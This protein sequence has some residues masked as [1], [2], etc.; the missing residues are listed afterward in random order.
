[1]RRNR[2]TIY[3]ILTVTILLLFYLT[4]ETQ[5]ANIQ[6][7][8]PSYSDVTA[9][10]SIASNGDTVHVPAGFGNWSNTIYL[11]KAITVKGAGA[12]ANDDD[13]CDSTT[14]TCITKTS[15]TGFMIQINLSSSNSPNLTR[16]TGFTFDAN[17]KGE[18]IM[19]LGRSKSEPSTPVP[20][21]RIDNCIFKN[22]NNTGSSSRT[23][24]NGSTQTAQVF[25]VIDSN[26]FIDNAK[27]AIDN[28]GSMCW[29]WDEFSAAESL[30]GVNTLYFEDNEIKFTNNPSYSCYNLGSHGW[31]GRSVWRYNIID[32]GKVDRYF[33]MLDAHG[34]QAEQD[35]K[36]CAHR[37]TVT[38]EVYRNRIIDNRGQQ[39]LDP[40]GGTVMIW[41]NI[42]TGGSPGDGMWISGREEDGPERFNWKS[43]WPGYDPVRDSYVW[44]NLRGN[45]RRNMS[46]K[47]GS[48]KYIKHNRDFWNQNDNFNGTNGIGIGP[49][50]NR[51]ETCTPA[52]R[53]SDPDVVDNNN[54]SYRGTGPGY[55]ATDQGQWNKSGNGEQGVL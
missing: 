1:M 36:N 11:S 35:T 24:L 52:R 45:V 50:A 25:G 38:V 46:V 5:A 47:S 28:Y 9:A 34:N 37:G 41:D 49:L 4:I 54:I 22:N 42:S 23:I 26:K 53:A 44:G 27:A 7:N 13:I 2:R 6:A 30:G 15:S 39:F 48:E 33:Q 18:G 51:P 3:C 10:I 21:V 55:W 40:R 8:S 14:D 12:D 19:S 20:F 31:G 17:H 32:Y 16:V 43:D 29:G